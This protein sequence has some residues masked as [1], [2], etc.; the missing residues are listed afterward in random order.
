MYAYKLAV[1]DEE[2]HPIGFSDAPEDDQDEWDE[3][4]EY[5]VEDEEETIG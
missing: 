3:D 4:W 2:F 5:Y 1:D